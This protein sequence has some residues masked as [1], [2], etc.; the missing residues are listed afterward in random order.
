M[1]KITFILL[2]LCSLVNCNKLYSQSFFRK[3]VLPNYG[4][5]EKNGKGMLIAA[6]DSNRILV[7]GSQQ[8]TYP[9]WHEWYYA[10]ALLTDSIGD[11]IANHG[12]FMPGGASMARETNLQGFYDFIQVPGGYGFVERGVCWKPLW[13]PVIG[14]VSGTVYINYR[15]QVDTVNVVDGIADGLTGQ[16]LYAFNGNIIFTGTTWN[17]IDTI[18]LHSFYAPD[19]PMWETDYYGNMIWDDS[20]NHTIYEPQIFYSIPATNSQIAVLGTYQPSTVV[21]S[22]PD[23]I[24]LINY[25]SIGSIMNDYRCSIMTNADSGKL[26]KLKNNILII[27]NDSDKV[28]GHL[29]LCIEVVDSI[30]HNFINAKKYVLNADTQDIT[31]HAIYSIDTIAIINY[32]VNGSNTNRFLLVN[33]LGDSITSFSLPPCTNWSYDNATNTILCETDTNNTFVVKDYAIGGPILYKYVYSAGDTNSHCNSIAALP[34]GKGLFIMTGS[35][36]DTLFIIRKDSQQVFTTTNQVKGESEKVKVY[37]NPSTGL[38]VITLSHAELVSSAAA[39]ETIEVYN[40]LGQSVYDGMLKQVQNDNRI[41]L[42]GQPQGIYFY[43]VLKEDGELLGEGK[44][45]IQ[46]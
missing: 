38:F 29:Q 20:L 12:D 31:P 1:R 32:V 33:S 18:Y 25:N 28:N 43:R 34:Q 27:A 5:T 2:F 36:N 19:A 16:N 39:D 26:I 9:A 10:F 15:M 46:K 41:D 23:T 4:G 17:W 30:G 6:V 8:S 40:V 45:I 37:P 42:S 11:T 21:G 24:R 35:I 13:G 14:G 44:L 3:Y 7:L 22:G